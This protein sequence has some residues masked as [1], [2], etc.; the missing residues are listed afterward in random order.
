MERIEYEVELERSDGPAE[1]TSMTLPPLPPSR[2]SFSHCPA[3][4]HGRRPR[5]RSRSLF[6]FRGAVSLISRPAYWRNRSGGRK[7]RRC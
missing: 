5:E 4:V 7:E 3:T 6:R 2:P 1:H